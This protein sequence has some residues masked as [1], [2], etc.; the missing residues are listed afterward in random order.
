MD[1]I[2]QANICTVFDNIKGG[3]DL[4][5]LVARQEA[6]EILVDIDTLI[7]LTIIP[8]D[9]PLPHDPSMRSEK[10]RQSQAGPTQDPRTL[11]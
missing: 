2:D 8:A 9:F 4:Q 5:V 7:D 11:G 6:E 10:C 3:R 1:V